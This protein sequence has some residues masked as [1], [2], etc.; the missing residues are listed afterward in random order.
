MLDNIFLKWWVFV[1]AIFTAAGFAQYQFNLLDLIWEQDIFKL[2]FVI[3]AV[4][5][6]IIIKNGYLAYHTQ[7]S[8]WAT[9]DTEKQWFWSSIL[10]KMGL[11]GTIVGFLAMLLSAGISF[12]SMDTSNVSEVI[13]LLEDITLGMATALWTTLVGVV[14]SQLVDIQLIY[15]DQANKSE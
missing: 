7:Y 1:C 9:V 3:M 4:F 8:E 12:E 6:A 10:T 13:M 11:T 14:C 2:S 15:I 5:F